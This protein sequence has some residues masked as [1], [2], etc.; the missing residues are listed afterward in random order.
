MEHPARP[1]NSNPSMFSSSLV[2]HYIIYTL[3][4]VFL[5]ITRSR[6]HCRAGYPI[7]RHRLQDQTRA[8]RLGSDEKIQM[9]SLPTTLQP[10]TCR[11]RW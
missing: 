3:S 5:L 8:E 9:E 7:N 2:G 10:R 4:G 1:G 11:G 6:R